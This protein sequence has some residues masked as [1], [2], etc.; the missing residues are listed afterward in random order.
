MIKLTG[1]IP[2]KNV[3]MVYLHLFFFRFSIS[4]HEPSGFCL[5]NIGVMY[6]PVSCSHFVI[7]PFTK[8]FW[9]SKFIADLSSFEKQGIWGS[10]FLLG[11]PKIPVSNPTPFVLSL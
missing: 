11:H 1:A 5:I 7:T 8:S 2:S 10:G 6:S 4:L 9:I 3:C